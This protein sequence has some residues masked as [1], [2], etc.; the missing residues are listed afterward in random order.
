[1]DNLFSKTY[2]LILPIGCGCPTAISLEK[3]RMRFVSCPFDWILIPSVTT[4]AELLTQRIEGLFELEDLVSEEEN[5]TC[6][7]VTNRRWKWLSVHDFPKD[8]T[9]EEGREIVMQKFQR[10]ISRLLERLDSGCSVLLYRL[11]YPLEKTMTSE[12]ELK[13]GLEQIKAAFPESDFSLLY[14]HNNPEL[15]YE[16][17]KEV[18]H[19]ADITSIQ[20]CYDAGNPVRNYDVRDALL[21]AVLRRISHS[22]RFVDTRAYRRYQRFLSNVGANE[23]E[24][25]DR[26]Y[27]SSDMAELIMK[28]RFVWKLAKFLY[29][30]CK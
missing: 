15:S 17:R 16:T 24:W 6:R 29:R 21:A 4:A 13:A 22:P 25:L 19:T 14:L 12:D 27:F 23:K 18:H 10:R 7:V 20:F 9:L 30:F 8:K 2:D 26:W 5:A 1:M 3:C 28:K 11:D